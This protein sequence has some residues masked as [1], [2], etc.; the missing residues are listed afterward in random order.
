MPRMIDDTEQLYCCKLFQV[1]FQHNLKMDP[2]VQYIMS[3]RA[4]RMY[5]LKLLRQQGMPPGQLSVA[6]HSIIVLRTL[7]ALPACKTS[8]KVTLQSDSITWKEDTG[9]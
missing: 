5:Q 7:Y 2:H 4:Q 3:Q 1:I 6:A 8:V 9:Q